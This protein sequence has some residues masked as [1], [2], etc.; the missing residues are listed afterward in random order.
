M[1]AEHQILS[2]VLEENNFYILNKFNLKETDFYTIPDVYSF[3]KRYV[4]EHGSVPDYRTVVAEFENFDYM[5]EVIDTFPYLAKTLKNATAKRGSIEILQKQAG[6]K[7]QELSGTA[8]VDWLGDEVEKLKGITNAESFAGLNYATSGQD[9]WEM[10]KDNKDNRSFKFIPTPYETLT[11]YLGGGFELGDYVL[12]QAYTNRGKSWVASHIAVKAWMSGFGI[13]HYSPELSE[14]QQ[15]Q[16][17]DTLVGHFNN[18]GLKTG[19]LGAEEEK[20]QS[21]LTM[22]NDKEQ[23]TP[24]IIKSMEHLPQG[25]SLDVIEADIIANPECKVVIIDGF[26][27]MQHKGRGGN[28]DSMSN[29]SRAL[30]QLFARHQVLGI[31]VHQTPTSAEKNKGEDEDGSRIVQPPKLHEYSETIAVIQDACTILSFD[32][33]DGVGMIEL[34]KTRTPNVDKSVTLHCDF[35]HGYIKEATAID[36]I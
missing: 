23:E 2:K 18:V 36:Y 11:R 21:F 34:S 30:R 31:V 28:R 16:R 9:R 35:N 27:L 13:L 20:Y 12:L 5:P 33:S 25:L 22:F 6:L 26:N 29:T 14:S 15:A 3:I 17:N 4:G 19:T 24:Y 7:F 10:Y 8:F 1:I 32:Q